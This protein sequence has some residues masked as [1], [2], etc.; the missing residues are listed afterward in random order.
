MA[1]GAD[2]IWVEDYGADDLTRILLPSLRTKHYPV[3][4]QPY[5]VAFAAGAAWATNY[6]DGT[7]TRVDATTGRRTTVKV[8][9]APVGI[10]PSGGALWVG[11][12]GDGTVSRIDAATLE[13]TTLKTGGAPGW[14]AYDARSVWVGDGAAGQVI[15]IDSHTG[16]ILARVDVGLEPN[17]GDV[18]AGALWLPDATAGLY[19]VDLATNKASGPYRL[20][21]ADPF[22]A[23]GYDGRL[24]IA[25]FKGTETFVVDLADLPAPAG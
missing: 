22:V 3:G 1:Y 7:V 13:V 19:R 25:D 16:R 23:D 10:A 15:R 9:I 2:S 5:D 14:T 20:G 4:S 18:F 8:G 11:N 6:G 24:W 12:Q 17:D 21:A